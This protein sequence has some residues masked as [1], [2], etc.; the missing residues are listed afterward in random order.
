MK[1]ALSLVDSSEPADFWRQSTPGI[2]ED[3]LDE[4]PTLGSRRRRL[5]WS[6]KVSGSTSP[7][8]KAL[9]AGRSQPRPAP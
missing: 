6:A 7:S 9:L 8:T 2:Q 1:Q 5:V 3:I 4:D